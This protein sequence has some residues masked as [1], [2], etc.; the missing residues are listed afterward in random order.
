MNCFNRQA[1]AGVP[2]EMEGFKKRC[3][4]GIFALAASV[5]LAVLLELGSLAFMQLIYNTIVHDASFWS[6]LGRTVT[7]F[8][9]IILNA[10]PMIAVVVGLWIKKKPVALIGAAAGILFAVVNFFST[11][12]NIFVNLFEHKLS[13]VSQLATILVDYPIILLTAIGYAA[14]A[15]T[16][17]TAYNKLRLFPLVTV[18]VHAFLAFFQFVQTV[19][20]L[21]QN[22]PMDIRQGVIG[23]F[24]VGTDVV[25]GLGMCISTL[26]VAFFGY[27]AMLAINKAAA[28]DNATVEATFEEVPAQDA[29]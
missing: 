5:V 6:G 9:S 25:H 29:E 24:A 13:F 7:G 15:F 26:C 23:F 4:L 20:G 16:I 1:L 22:A 14:L 12:I 18:G 3:K 2:G 21:V 28:E 27:F 17:L 11:T 8:F 19:V 10:A